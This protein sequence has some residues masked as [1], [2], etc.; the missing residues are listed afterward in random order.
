MDITSTHS[1]VIAHALYPSLVNVCILSG[2]KPRKS[3]KGS[4]SD[5]SL[6]VRKQPY[7]GTVTCLKLWTK[8]CQCIFQ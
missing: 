1:Y 8:L 3:V 2:V 5:R 6:A 7:L 4:R